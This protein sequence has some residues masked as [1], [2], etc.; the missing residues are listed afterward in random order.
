MVSPTTSPQAVPTLVA[1]TR[2]GGRVVVVVVDVDVVGGGCVVAVVVVVDTSGN[3]A[4]S[5]AED[6]DVAAGSGAVHAA[7]HT[8]MTA[9]RQSRRGIG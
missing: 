8:A 9:R 4:S 7:A 3:G 2:P 5:G 1:G 6:V